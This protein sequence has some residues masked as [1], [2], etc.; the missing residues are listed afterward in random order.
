M[1][2]AVAMAASCAKEINPDVVTPEVELVPMEFVSSIETK[3]QLASDGLNVQWIAGD[4]ITV[5]DG[6]NTES[7]TEN[8]VE[9]TYDQGRKFVAQSA[10]SA[11]SFTGE[12]AVSA[13]EYYAVYPYS[14]SAKMNAT[15]NLMTAS[16]PAQQTAV[17]GSF[18]DDLSVLVAKAD[19]N[20]LNFKNVCS[21]VKF[22]LASDLTDIKSITLMGNKSEAVAGTF[23]INWNDGSPEV[24][25]TNAETY[26]TLRNADASFLAPGDYYFTVLPVDFTE[27][28]TVI[29]SKTDGTQLTKKGASALNVER[30]KVVAT[31]PLASSNYDTKALNYF[32]KYN[33]GFDIIYG[34]VTI[35][36]STYG[37]AVR[38]GSTAIKSDGVYFI[39]TNNTVSVEYNEINKL[40][41]IG[42]D[43]SVRST[44]N[45]TKNPQP[46][47][48][49]SGIFLCANLNYTL[50]RIEMKGD[51]AKI[52]FDGCRIINNQDGFLRMNNVA[53][54]LT[55][56]MI[57]DCD[58]QITK[59]NNNFITG[60]TSGT[61]ISNTIFDNNVF[62]M[63]SDVVMTDFRLL[64]EGTAGTVTYE[65]VTMSYNTF[66]KTAIKKY[67]INSTNACTNV[68]IDHNVFIENNTTTVI[69][70]VLGTV[71]T[72][73]EVKDNFYHLGAY[74]KSVQFYKEFEGNNPKQ[75]SDPRPSDWDPA[76]GI[77]YLNQI[78]YSDKTYTAG[79][80]RGTTTSASADAAAYSYS[81][82]N[83]GNL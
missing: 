66:E 35:N 78:T 43:P 71:P 25:V 64:N 81:S 29:L 44:V 70:Y 51:F 11:T 23:T 53:V 77:C 2:A 40:I 56:F 5:F 13:A 74:T 63:A 46:Q 9:V 73:L 19:G 20:T 14:S 16:L 47:D 54:N 55:D 12:A 28:F 8:D 59:T 57:K 49:S 60:N 33:D 42:E 31:K 3:T 1:F 79:A 36:K 83:M 7:V 38:C 48:N 26:V 69:Q 34:G 65:N 41:I 72:N 45:Q 76:N 75:I 15:S 50:K 37:D 6:T 52:M 24:K 22:T 17:A 18:A 67:M 62:Y 27:G 82:V 68:T 21:L 32:V 58:I 80:Q 4:E 30:N 10:G 61:K 39:P